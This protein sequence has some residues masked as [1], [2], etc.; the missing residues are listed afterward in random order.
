MLIDS[1]VARSCFRGVSFWLFLCFRF[2]P[3]KYVWCKICSSDIALS[4]KKQIH[5]FG[6]HQDG[7]TEFDTFAK[8]F[9]SHVR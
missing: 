7:L 5:G 4:N 1:E 6:S 9:A 2:I 3:E 8:T